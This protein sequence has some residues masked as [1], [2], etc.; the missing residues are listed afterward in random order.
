MCAFSNAS[1]VRL[2]L[3][4]LAPILQVRYEITSAV[5]PASVLVSG[6]RF[7]LNTSSHQFTS[8][9]LIFHTLSSLHWFCAQTDT[10][11]SIQ[12][13]KWI[14]LT[15][16]CS[17]AECDFIFFPR[18]A[19]LVPIVPLSRWLMYIIIIDMYSRS[20]ALE[21]S[22]FT[23]L[24]KLICLQKRV[25]VLNML[26]R[27]LAGCLAASSLQSQPPS[28]WACL[29]YILQ[30]VALGVDKIKL[31]SSSSLLLFT[32]APGPRGSGQLHLRLLAWSEKQ[33]HN[34]VK[35]FF[36]W[37]NNCK[38]TVSSRF[39]C[40]NLLTFRFMKKFVVNPPKLFFAQITEE[41]CF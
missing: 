16:W 23:M 21:V 2:P 40:V 22:L 41:K 39:H 9:L 15:M 33:K 29:E 26:H 31:A 32:L 18:Q 12:I 7:L 8:P 4:Y 36:I 37:L 3:L 38:S 20:H 19:F 14:Y 17:I 27:C 24:Q 6:C 10:K 5:F 28:A 34:V 25:A 35:I 30:Y 13:V 1:S 11:L